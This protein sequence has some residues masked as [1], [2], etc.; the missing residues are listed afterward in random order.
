M[1]SGT[2][3]LTKSASSGR[4]IEGKIDWTSTADP[5][6][7]TSSVTAKLY[8]RKGHTDMALTEATDGIWS[9]K[10]TVDG[11]EWTGTASK[12]VLED[13]VFLTTRTVS[14]ILHGTGGAKSI[15]I[16]GSV[17]APTGTLF[18]GHT[19]KGSKTVALDTITRTT[20]INSLTCTKN[21]QKHDY[22]DGTITAVYTTYNNEYYNRYIVNVNVN[23][24]LKEIYSK[25]LDKKDAKQHQEVL[26]FT[27]ENRLS[28]LY[29]AVPNSTKVTISVT[30]QTYSDSKYTSQ[31]GSDQ[32]LE[33][34]LSL[35]TSVVPTIN[36]FKVIPVNT[37][38]WI[39]SLTTKIFVAGLSGATATLSATAGSGANLKSTTITYDNT[40]TE[41]V[42]LDVSTLKK[43]DNIKFTAKALDTRG[44]SATVE[45]TISVLSYSAP[46][47]TSMRAERGTYGNNVWKADGSGT[48]VKLVFKTTL[49]LTDYDNAYN[50]EFEIDGS[51][52]E[53]SNSATTE[54]KSATDYTVYFLD[55]DGEASRTLTM[56]ATDSVGKT[57]T[58]KLTI[59]TV[60]ITMEFNDSGK[61]I[62]FGKTSEMEEGFECAWDAEFHGTVKRIRA[63]GSI[64]SLDDTGWIDI[65]TSTSVTAT[66]KTEFG[67]YI[68]CAYRVVNGNHVYVAFN[69]KATRSD[70]AV[71]VNSE[72]IPVDYR[73]K[74]QPYAIAALS[75]DR[76]ARI[77]V[78]PDGEVAIDW[79]HYVNDTVE[80]TSHTATWIDGYIDYFI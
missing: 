50:V 1:A 44:R 34:T 5:F 26:D 21:G 18:E 58:A 51:P 35:P 38:K 57:G 53:P 49:E 41:T 67:H 71:I 19:T 3:N 37:N 80:P 66:E 32:S 54:L 52:K 9:Y 14:S 33:I 30:F 24:A 47:I 64:L 65:G 36:E 79:I 55:V 10:L 2:I 72:A 31:T 69:V 12:A 13:W 8:V 4:Y 40:T 11:T 48:A 16:S 63:D 6:T 77:L 25:K 39:D 61:G 27:V 74:L 46:A 60:H 7:G 78:T 15:T 29:A 22:V 28:K 45:K 59:P 56:T 23:G 17:T 76:V 73:P 62:A 68:G 20:T 42:K 75:S 70:K 43:S